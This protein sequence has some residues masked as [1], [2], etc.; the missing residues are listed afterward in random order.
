M[1]SLADAQPGDLIVLKN[2]EHIV[3]YAGD[4]KV[5]HAPD[6]GRTVSE[7]PN[8]LTDADIETIRRVAPRPPPRRRAASVPHPRSPARR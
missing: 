6:V 5:I 4:G 2:N 1:P 7:V 8:W 3:I